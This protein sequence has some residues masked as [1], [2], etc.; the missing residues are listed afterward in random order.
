MNEDLV[1]GI[2]V[3]KPTINY[4]FIRTDDGINYET[5]RDNGFIGIGWNYITLDDINNKTRTEVINKIAKTENID[6]TISKQKGKATGIYNKIIKFSQLKKGD[7]VIIP[8]SGSSSLSFGVIAEDGI[9]IDTEKSFDCDYYKRKKVDWKI[10]KNISELDKAFFLI[11]RSQHS[12]GTVNGYAEYIDSVI[13][14]LYEKDGFSHLVLN[15]KTHEDISWPDLGQTLVEMYELMTVV[16]EVFD[17]N[18]DVQHSSIRL[19]LQ[20]PGIL[21]FKQAGISLFFLAMVLGSSSCN[22]QT[23]EVKNKVRQVQE[24]KHEKI[25]SINDRLRSLNVDIP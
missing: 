19:N 13:Y 3:V 25:D 17:L 6:I 11:K 24:E 14:N 22:N 21:N 16:K 23:D 2:E 10:E 7:V 1:K 18:E 20:S 5:F 12:I 8:S 15:V 4:W 9:T